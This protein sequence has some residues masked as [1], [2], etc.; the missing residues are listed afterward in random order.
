M[1]R[2]TSLAL[3]RV[4]ARC[5]PEDGLPRVA[6]WPLG[7]ACQAQARRTASGA[8]PMAV[9]SWR[10]GPRGS[11]GCCAAVA[12]P[13][14]GLIEERR[15]RLVN[16]Q[17]ATG[18]AG[19]RL[20]DVGARRGAGTPARLVQY[21]RTGKGLHHAKDS[22]TRP[23]AREVGLMRKVRR[24]F[25]RSCAPSRARFSRQAPRPSCCWNG[26]YS[27][28]RLPA[29]S[30]WRDHEPSWRAPELEG[31]PSA[32]A[33]WLASA[34]AASSAAS[35]CSARASAA[36]ERARSAARRAGLEEE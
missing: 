26:H 24:R 23:T 21:E 36:R 31:G 10:G 12:P 30:R 20:D 2:A 27:P 7:S 25:M 4:Y 17:P 5:L 32:P 35:A 9:H 18:G 34:W 3:P 16:R 8:E 6:S 29:A 13:R 28:G 22:R 11:R 14:R 33:S 19:C 15:D 1:V